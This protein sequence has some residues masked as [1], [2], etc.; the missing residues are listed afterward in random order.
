[1]SGLKW[2]TPEPATRGGRV[3]N[4]YDAIV[5]GLR[6]RPGQWALVAENASRQNFV[7][8]LKRRGAEVTTRGIGPDV[9]FAER[10]YARW[11]EAVES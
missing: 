11:P 4:N 10:I 5:A 2:E 9:N 8:A 1:M 7:S 6:E 3:P